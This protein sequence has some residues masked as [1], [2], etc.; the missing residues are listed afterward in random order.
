MITKLT[1]PELILPTLILII[2]AAASIPYFVKGDWRHGLY[3]AAAALL[4]YAVTY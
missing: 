3:W 2:Q 4:T 1:K